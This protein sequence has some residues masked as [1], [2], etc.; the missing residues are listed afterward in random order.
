MVTNQNFLNKF[1]TA[2]GQEQ[3]QDEILKGHLPSGINIY[4]AKADYTHPLKKNAKFEAGLKVSFVK[5]DNDAQ[6]SLFENNQ[7]VVDSGRTNNFLYQENI[8]A[9]YV[10]YNKQIGKWG[11]QLGL[12][13]EQTQAKGK[14]FVNDSSFKRNYSNLFPTGYI[15]YA[16][17][18]Q[19]SVWVIIW[20]E[21]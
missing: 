21:N 14:Q 7:W 13:M 2:N 8:Y 9:G 19:E 12:R 20:Q 3:R 4:S 1:Y 16:R 18:R 6:Y 15:S 10:N 11:I 17:E 5:T